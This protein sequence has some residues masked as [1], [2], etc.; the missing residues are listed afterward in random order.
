MDG[1]FTVISGYATESQGRFERSAEVFGPN[2]GVWSMV[3]NMW[4]I[5]GCP[6]SCIAA[7]GCLYFFQ[8]KQVISYKSKENVWEVVA[9][10]P[11]SM[12]VASCATVWRDR[13]FVSGSAQT[14]DK[15]VCYMLENKE[16]NLER[17]VPIER[18]QNF[19]GFV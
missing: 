19:V 12:N 13:I 11:K 16:G 8:K 4:S 17:W 6:R 10:L 18:A 7:L 14:V 5:G 2:T 3:E 9:C 15:Q 1:K